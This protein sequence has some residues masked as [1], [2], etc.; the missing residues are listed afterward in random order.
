MEDPYSY[1]RFRATLPPPH[2]NMFDYLIEFFRDLMVEN[3]ESQSKYS[4]LI[5]FL[6][7][8]MLPEEYVNLGIC[9]GVSRNI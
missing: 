4:Y 3:M 9:T 6:S 2:L 1:F 5:Y 7:I 8:S